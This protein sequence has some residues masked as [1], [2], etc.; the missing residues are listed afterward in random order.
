MRKIRFRYIK[1]NGRATSV[2]VRCSVKRKLCLWFRYILFYCSKLQF[3]KYRNYLKDQKKTLCTYTH[4]LTH[5]SCVLFS[6][7]SLLS[8]WHLTYYVSI[9]CA[10]ECPSSQFRCVLSLSLVN[11]KLLSWTV[12]NVI[13]I[14]RSNQQKQGDDDDDDGGDGKF[15]VSHLLNMIENRRLSMIIEFFRGYL[16]YCVHW[17]WFDRLCTEGVETWFPL[18]SVELTRIFDFRLSRQHVVDLRSTSTLSTFATSN[19]QC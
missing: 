10:F 3:I 4:T 17:D 15:V 2:T 6:S 9:R 13:V 11:I 8:H 12:G 5:R 19:K 16:Y 14:I 18:L 1:E 7:N